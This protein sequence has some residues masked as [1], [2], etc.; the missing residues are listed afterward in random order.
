V[1]Q[2]FWFC[3]FTGGGNGTYKHVGIPRPDTAI[4]K[5]A[6]QAA[7]RAFDRLI[8]NLLDDLNLGRGCTKAKEQY[9]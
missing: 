9:Y 4:V 1:F 8:A 7:A 5:I 6:A 3:F 2:D